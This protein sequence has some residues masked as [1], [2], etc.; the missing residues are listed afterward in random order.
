LP[1]PPPRSKPIRIIGQKLTESVGVQTVLEARGGGNAIIG[2]SALAK[3][4]PDGYTIMVTIM[5]FGSNNKT[6]GNG[7]GFWVNR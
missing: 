4:P 3:S 5:D 6:P 7:T 1:L 2:T